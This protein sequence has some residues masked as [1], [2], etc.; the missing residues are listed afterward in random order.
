MARLAERA[1][2]GVFDAPASAVRAIEALRSARLDAEQVSVAA[3]L[4]PAGAPPASASGRDAERPTSWLDALRPAC[5]WLGGASTV[6]ATG[7]GQV[8]G[9]GPL[10]ARLAGPARGQALVALEDLGV[11]HQDALRYVERLEQG[12]GLMVVGVPDRVVAE[13]ARH[14]LSGAGAVE[15]T[16]FIGRPYGTA[17]HGAGPGA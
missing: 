10:L 6:E 16:Y 9:A 13:Q 11:A 17:Y 2:V 3:R 1:V 4:A 15:A 12:G 14:L 8:V 7:L 5:G